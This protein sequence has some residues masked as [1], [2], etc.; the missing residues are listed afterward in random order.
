MAK[1]PDHYPEQCPPESAEP[2]S[3]KVYRFVNRT[4]P[5]ER[6]FKSNYEQRPGTDWGNQGCQ[7]RGLSVFR[8]IEACDDMAEQ[9]P[10]LA[11]KKLAVANLS[12]NDGVIAETPSRNSSKH[13]TL[14]PL[15]DAKE[16][17]NRFKSVDIEE[18]ANA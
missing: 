5:K 11:K 13:N 15:L 18:A 2:V 4:N 7:A 17:A 6:D 10:A 16:M 8:T 14:W 9:V 3:G 1:W 12:Q